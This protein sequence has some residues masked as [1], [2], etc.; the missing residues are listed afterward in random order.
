MASYYYL[1]ASLPELKKD[2]ALPISYDNFL[3]LCNNAVN[4]TV[5]RNLSELT[6]ETGGGSLSEKWC[7]FCPDVKKEICRLRNINLGKQAASSDIKHP[8]TSKLA[9]A[10]MHAEN[11]LK[12]EKILLE[13][14]FDYLDSLMSLHFFDDT[15]LYGY[16]IKLRLLERQS[17]F[18]TEL[19]KSEFRRLFD[20]IQQQIQN[21]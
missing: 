14:Q 2:G 13:A 20:N 4:R 21:I 15:V 3:E 1:L 12:A 6:V 8:A 5:Y 7:S 18:D 11:P 9:E 17:L 16:A 10:V 19:G